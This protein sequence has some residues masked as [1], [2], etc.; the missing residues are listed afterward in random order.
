MVGC[1]LLLLLLYLLQ[2]IVR[3]GA[4]QDGRRRCLLGLLLPPK[5][6]SR[7]WYLHAG[8]EGGQGLTAL[9]QDCQLLLLRKLHLRLRF[10]HLSIG[11]WHKHCWLQGLLRLLLLQLL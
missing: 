8:R 11:P 4:T 1:M 2:R 7:R 10:K 9:L 3:Q 6:C 5:C